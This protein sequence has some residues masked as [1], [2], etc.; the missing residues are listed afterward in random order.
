MSKELTEQYR[1]GTLPSDFYYFT[2]GKDFYTIEHHQLKGLPA[3]KGVEVVAKVPSYDEWKTAYECQLM[4]S[5]E[6][7]TLKEQLEEANAIIK[8]LKDA[9][10]QS[11][12]EYIEKYGV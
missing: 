5:E 6:V 10:S 8:S 11:V 12:N 2:N 3:V 4:E 9:R 1:N 7:L